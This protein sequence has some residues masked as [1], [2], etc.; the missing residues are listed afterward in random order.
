MKRKRSR[1][2]LHLVTPEEAA[3]IRQQAAAAAAEAASL[4][5]DDEER[6]PASDEELDEL[7]ASGL[8]RY[9]QLLD[10]IGAVLSELQLLRQRL[11]RRGLQGRI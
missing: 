1:R 11:A 7:L 9:Q 6:S 8:R 10:H 3:T 4:L 2:G 5:A